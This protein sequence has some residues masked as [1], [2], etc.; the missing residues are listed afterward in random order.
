MLQF[1]KDE[2]RGKISSESSP[3]SLYLDNIETSR[4]VQ[5]IS[6]RQLVG[7]DNGGD[8]SRIQRLVVGSGRHGSQLQLLDLIWQQT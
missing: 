1:E 2:T 7:D 8:S 6:G 5:P 4:N 3:E